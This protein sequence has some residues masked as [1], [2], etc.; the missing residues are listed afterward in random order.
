MLRT[1]S[2]A[3]AFGYVSTTKQVSE[4]GE[5]ERSANARALGLAI[6]WVCLV[7]Y[8]SCD[9]FY[10]VLHWAYK[11]DCLRMQQEAEAEGVESQSLLRAGR[12]GGSEKVAGRRERAGE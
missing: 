1:A 8:S 12:E 6:W 10:C 2:L 3:S 5:L 11:K 9:F 4:M 7:C